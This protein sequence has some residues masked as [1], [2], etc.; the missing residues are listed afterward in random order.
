MRK[1][2]TIAVFSLFLLNIAY[3]QE[4]KSITNKDAGKATKT[5][6]SNDTYKLNFSLPDGEW[7]V[8]DDSMSLIK[9]NGKVVEFWK[10]NKDIRIGVSIEESDTPL[11]EMVKKGSDEIA[12]KTAGR[13]VV[14]LRYTYNKVLLI[15]DLKYVKGTVTAQDKNMQTE[16]NPFYYSQVLEATSMEGQKFRIENYLITTKNVGAVR[17]NLFIIY[18]LNTYFD[19]RTISSDLLKSLVLE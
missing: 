2:I 18:P 6:Y 9:V 16:R 1:I 7:M 13:N 12:S 4:K 19:N 15:E 5:S 3:S 17:I 11:I 14:S 10:V 8:L